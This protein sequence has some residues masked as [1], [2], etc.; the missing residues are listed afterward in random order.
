[1]DGNSLQSTMI[2][3]PTAILQQNDLCD[4]ETATNKQSYHSSSQNS[5]N[6]QHH[7]QHHHSNSHFEKAK[8]RKY[9]YT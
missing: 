4:Q 7:L 1:M 9:S 8:K 3:H 6:H 2:D 5:N